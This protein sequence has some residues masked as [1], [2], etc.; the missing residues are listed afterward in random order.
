MTIVDWLVLAVGG[1]SCVIG[2]MRGFVREA[3]SLAGWVL[4]FYAAKTLAPGFSAEVPGIDNP[5][6][7]Y[8]VALVLV[9]VVVLLLASLASMLLRGMVNMVGLGA[10]DKAVGLLFGGARALVLLLSLTVVAGLTSLPKT[11]AWQDSWS[12]SWLESAVVAIK[13]WLPEDLAALIQFQ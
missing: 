11:R 4:A 8:G 3:M 10:Y 9:F 6:L 1:L 2:L 7:R 5:A 13:P 12:H